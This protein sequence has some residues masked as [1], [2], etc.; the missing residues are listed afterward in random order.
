MVIGDAADLFIIIQH[1]I[2]VYIVGKKR[3]ADLIQIKVGANTQTVHIFR[4]KSVKEIAADLQL[5]PTAYRNLEKG[6]SDISISK[7]S[8]LAIVFNVGFYQFYELD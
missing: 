1:E 2:T 8:K 4:N 6:I 5:C 3:T 7:L